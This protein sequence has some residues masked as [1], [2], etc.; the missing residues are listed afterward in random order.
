MQA[1]AGLLNRIMLEDERRLCRQAA[2]R[3][4]GL[5]KSPLNLGTLLT[6]AERRDPTLESSLVQTFKDFATE[7]CCP[8][9]QEVVV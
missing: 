9:L 5:L 7:E 6:L 2:I 3:A 8:F 4:A 1:A